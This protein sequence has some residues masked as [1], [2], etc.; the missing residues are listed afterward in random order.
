MMILQIETYSGRY[1]NE[2]ISLILSI[3]N[4][5]AKINLPIQ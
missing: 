4:N 3:Q 2:I 5:E 1:D